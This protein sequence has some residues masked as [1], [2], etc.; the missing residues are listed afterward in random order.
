ML[1]WMLLYPIML[2]SFLATSLWGVVVFLFHSPVDVWVMISKAV[3]Q[4][5]EEQ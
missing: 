4:A 1:V 2:L 5:L 3:D